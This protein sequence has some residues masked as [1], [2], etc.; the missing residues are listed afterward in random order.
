MNKLVLFLQTAA[1]TFDSYSFK[2]RKMLMLLHFLRLA[3]AVVE[4]QMNCT[5]NFN[6]QPDE[7]SGLAV[8]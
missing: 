6:C 2:Y 4:E 1:Q 7:A 3:G 5:F 8:G